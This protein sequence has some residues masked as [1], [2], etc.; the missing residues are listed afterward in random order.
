[1]K[2]RRGSG[3]KSGGK[4]PRKKKIVRGGTVWES[5]KSKN[6][7]G[8][9]NDEIKKR[10]ELKLDLLGQGGRRFPEKNVG[11]LGSPTGETKNPRK[12]NNKKRREENSRGG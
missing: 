8:E 12:N 6:R 2:E 11:G 10:R 7:G 4:D 5:S 3:T 9:T 1:L